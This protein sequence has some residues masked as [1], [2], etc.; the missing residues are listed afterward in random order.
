MQPG[1]WVATSFNERMSSLVRIVRLVIS[2][3]STAPS[4]LKFHAMGSWTRLSLASSDLQRVSVLP[5]DTN[6]D[7]FLHACWG[8]GLDRVVSDL[9]CLRE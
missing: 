6:S 1:G 5:G 4:W 9:V 7:H 3:I 2:K 8:R